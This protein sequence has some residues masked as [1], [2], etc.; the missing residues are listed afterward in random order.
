MFNPRDK[1]EYLLLLNIVNSIRGLNKMVTEKQ[2][3]QIQ[4]RKIYRSIVHS[5]S[6]RLSE[7]NTDLVKL[8][9][10]RK[11]VKAKV[12]VT[13]PS[14]SP[15][16]IVR[17]GILNKKYGGQRRSNVSVNEKA[18]TLD[19][20]GFSYKLLDS[21][22]HVPRFKGLYIDRVIKEIDNATDSNKDNKSENGENE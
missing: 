8:N 5:T 6:E 2:K 18:D 13:M 20:R 14:E 15:A 1:Q 21:R 7:I 3:R 10:K 12:V 16:I 9:S 22:N 17:I 19:N 11:S 4:K